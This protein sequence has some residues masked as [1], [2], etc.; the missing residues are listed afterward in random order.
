MT[1]ASSSLDLYFIS[2]NFLLICPKRSSIGE[3][4]KQEKRGKVRGLKEMIFYQE[5]KGEE[6]SFAFILTVLI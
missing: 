2:F 6:K 1:T 4:S 5:Y 3:N